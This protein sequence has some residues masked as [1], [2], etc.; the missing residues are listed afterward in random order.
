MGKI[1]PKLSL[2]KNHKNDFKV[3]KHPTLKQILTHN[4]T[5]VKFRNNT[6]SKENVIEFFN[7]III[8]LDGSKDEYTLLTYALK[9]HNIG[10]IAI[11]SPSHKDK[12]A[13]G[14]YRMRIFVNANQLNVKNYAYQ[15]RQLFKD[16][17]M[18][19]VKNTGIDKSAGD[20]SRYY[21]PPVMDGI[22]EPKTFD[23]LTGR[24]VVKKPK[25]R[26]IDME[27]ALGLVKVNEGKAYK[28]KSRFTKK[29][30]LDLI[31]PPKP[32]KDAKSF[33]PGTN[34]Y[35]VHIAGDKIINTQYGSMKFKKLNKRCIKNA[36]HIRCDCPFDAH[37]HGD[38]VGEDYAFCNG[39]GHLICGSEDNNGRHSH[40]LG[41]IA[42]FSKIDVGDVW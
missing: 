32:P 6:R 20:I 41:V 24:W 10:F 42:P 22:K 19:L 8:D 40:I 39:S 4:Y 37:E 2:S 23:S 26:N 7:N 21:Y 5:G 1:I 17:G 11:P 33:D 9:V 34:K 36:E 3:I 35:I 38:G 13:A 12:L 28:A 18:D 31:P 15:Y 16:L 29:D 27:Y 14:E 30:K 25:P